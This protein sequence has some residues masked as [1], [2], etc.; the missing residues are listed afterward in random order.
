MRERVCVIRVGSGDGGAAKNGGGC[1]GAAEGETP[2]FF[3]FFLF[4]SG[5]V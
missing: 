1:G 3:V 2:L 5:Y 4:V